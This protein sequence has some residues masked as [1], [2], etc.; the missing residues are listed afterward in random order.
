MPLH[1]GLIGCG[2]FS[3][4][5]LYAWRE[6]EEAEIVAVC[7]VDA[8]RANACANEFNIPRA[9][10]RADAMLEGEDLDFVDIV[11]QAH[12]H[13]ELVELAASRGIAII[14]QKPLAPSLE[15]SRQL[16]ASSSTVPFMVHENFRWQ[17]PML[18]LKRAVGAIGPLFYGRIAFRSA[19]DVYASQPYL[20]TDERFIL[21]DLGVHLFDLAR[22]FLGEMRSLT[23]HTARVNPEIVGEDVATALLE[24][25]YGG[26]AVVEM[27][28]AS[29]LETELFPQTLV[30]LEG[31]EGSAILGPDYTITVAS[32]TG[33]QKID[34]SPRSLAWSGHTATAIPESVLNIQRHW[35]ECLLTGRSPD[36]SGA[37]NLRTL[38]LV[39]GS[40]SSSESGEPYRIRDTARGL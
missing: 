33:V 32:S 35:V 5:H 13:R 26:H 20:S 17:R 28:Y 29:R 37:D 6:I 4:N 15:E 22:F 40:Y 38:E 12:T 19:F 14:C 36:T 18:E 21:Y 30:Q 3:R 23:C 8:H 11:T 27:S 9:Y 25:A 10:D 34:A 16:V 1:G 39:F 31:A 7:D 24:S 2:Y